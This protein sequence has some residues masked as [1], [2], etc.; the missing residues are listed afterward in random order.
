[1]AYYCC[2]IGC[3]KNFHQPANIYTAGKYISGCFCIYAKWLKI[4]GSLLCYAKY[5][6]MIVKNSITI[7]EYNKRRRQTQTKIFSVNSLLLNVYL[8]HWGLYCK[9]IIWIFEQHHLAGFM[10]TEK[11]VTLTLCAA[12]LILFN[13]Q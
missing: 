6:I 13:I 4:K 7:L 3:R 10:N 5:K 8:I 2:V 11:K 9:H 12:P 1:M